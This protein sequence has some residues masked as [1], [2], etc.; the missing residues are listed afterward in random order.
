MLY[1]NFTLLGEELI[2]EWAYRLPLR[3]NRLITALE[4]FVCG[5]PATRVAPSD[6][7]DATV[8]VYMTPPRLLLRNVS[9]SAALV[10]VDMQTK[11][12]EIFEV[13]DEYVETDEQYWLDIVERAQRALE[14]HR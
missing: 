10:L 1:R 11:T 6:P 12:V 8:E 13:I 4:E 2:A 3:M 14:N 9:D 5:G 7:A